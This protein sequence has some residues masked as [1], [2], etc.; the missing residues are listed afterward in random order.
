MNQHYWKGR[1]VTELTREELLEVVEFFA[2]ESLRN[3]EEIARRGRAM[4]PI[5]YLLDSSTLGAEKP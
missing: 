4:D 3:R 1:P 2:Q 5:K